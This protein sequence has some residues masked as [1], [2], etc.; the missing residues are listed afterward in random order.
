[1]ELGIYTKGDY[2]IEI[3]QHFTDLAVEAVRRLST[4]D[5]NG[6]MLIISLRK[7]FGSAI[8]V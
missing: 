6:E 4:C 8:P 2:I 5:L 3:N 1:M 7:F